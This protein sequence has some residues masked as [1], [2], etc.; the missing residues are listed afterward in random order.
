MNYI[1]LEHLRGPRA[2]EVEEFSLSEYSELVL[3][4][5]PSANIRFAPD[6]TLVGR[7]H[8]KLGPDPTNPDRFLLTDLNSRNGTFINGHRVI[9]TTVIRPGDAF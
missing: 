6:D 3:G 2:N 5:D 4:R 8:L 9:G 7:Q 1:V